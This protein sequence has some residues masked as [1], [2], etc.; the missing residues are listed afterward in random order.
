[1]KHKPIA[2]VVIL[3]IS[4]LFTGCVSEN[5]FKSKDTVFEMS[6]EEM[7]IKNDETANLKIRIT[8][9]GNSTIHPV[10]RFN[11]NSSD[12]PY[13]NFSRESY[14]MGSL[15]PGEDSGYRI[16][17]VKARLA[18]GSE[19]KYPVKVEVVDGSAVLYSKEILIT[20]GR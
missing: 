18:A 7:K 5:P 6:P 8:N 10:V 12:K 14:D 1:M 4:I 13:V 11:M 16:V 2:A 9:N 15:R 20:V 17:D 3:I 19:I